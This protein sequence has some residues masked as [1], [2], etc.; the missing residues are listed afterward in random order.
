[1]RGQTRGIS[2]GVVA[3]CF[4]LGSAARA[5]EPSGASGSSL[6]A[7]SVGARLGA[8]ARDHEEISGPRDPYAA[9]PDVGY[10]NT[11]LT[12]EADVG[13]HF[14]PSLTVYGFWEH[15]F[16]F[17]ST[18][19]WGDV[20]GLGLHAE[21]RPSAPVSLFVDLGQGYRWVSVPMS[22]VPPPRAAAT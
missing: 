12:V 9:A 4:P 22:G 16:F 18:D 14:V 2:T 19:P 10:F 15:A 3:L 8:I 13:Y 20:V 17:D 7:L 5:G 6:G 1:M 21:S 11:G